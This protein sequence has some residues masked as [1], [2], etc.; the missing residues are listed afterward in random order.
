[1]VGER[2]DKVMQ[3]DP[4][5]YDALRAAVG[6][7]AT[8]AE[9]QAMLDGWKLE[10]VKKR[11]ERVAEHARGLATRLGK[12]PLDIEVHATPLRLDARRFR[13]FWSAFGHVIRNAV[14]HGLE[15]PEERA[16]AGK[17]VVGKLVLRADEVAS[18][19][20][21]EVADDGRGIDWSTL[22]A[23]A[24]ERGVV[25]GKKEDALFADGVTTRDSAGDVSGRGV[26]MSAVRAACVALGGTVEVSSEPGKG[27]VV[28]FVFS[29]GNDANL[30]KGSHGESR[31]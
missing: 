28:R 26:G 12:G 5:E 24:R 15:K 14:D 1:L 18:G 7:G 23:R 27:T 20:T 2:E 6:R 29:R 19:L 4:S 8:K 3:L 21:I 13:S 11:L 16:A 31:N 30:T 25:V 9:L 10:P 17:P 22:T